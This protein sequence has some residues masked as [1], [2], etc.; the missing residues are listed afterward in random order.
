MCM[1][2]QAGEQ[3]GR[4]SEINRAWF[5]AEVMFSSK[6][7]KSAQLG[8]FDHVINSRVSHLLLIGHASSGLLKFLGVNVDESNGENLTRVVQRDAVE[9]SCRHA[10]AL[11]R[12]PRGD[13]I[14]KGCAFFK[15]AAENGYEH[16]G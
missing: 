15:A 10:E 2:A 5:V 11:I 4:R 13:E 12:L 9:D 6:I 3:A 1:S 7:V 16:R 14:L 8:R